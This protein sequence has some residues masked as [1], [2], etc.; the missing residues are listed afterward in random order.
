MNAAQRMARIAMGAALEN[1]TQTAKLNQWQFEWRI[2]SDA[3]VFQLAL[4]YPA[5]IL[6][7][8]IR[9]RVTNRKQYRPTE[10]AN[11]VCESLRHVTAPD[12]SCAVFVFS[13]NERMELCKLI[14]EADSIILSSQP[15]RS[16]FLDKVRFDQP[17]CAVVE[18]GLSLGSLEVSAF[19]R[20][21]LRMMPWIPD[22]LLRNGGG[23]ALFRKAAMD[24]ASSSAGFC[25]VLAEGASA[26]NDY[27]V[28]QVF[29][30]AWLALTEQNFACQPMMSLLVLRNILENGSEHVI[31]TIN[32]SKSSALLVQFKAFI[33]KITGN[34]S[35]GFPSALLRFGLADA[36][37]VRTGRLPMDQLITKNNLDNA[38]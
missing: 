31:G 37:S 26:E 8:T 24:L 7:A 17:V 4:D 29:E 30:R 25:V 6:N 14:S 19:Q 35:T 1:M 11:D 13:P 23:P 15:I 34:D 12:D 38:K 18:E 32:R 27:K 9:D 5:G 20:A 28:G 10:L 3:L 16:S 2:E 21:A 22:G 33:G 36:P